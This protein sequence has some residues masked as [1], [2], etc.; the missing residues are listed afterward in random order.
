MTVTSPSNDEIGLWVKATKPVSYIVK[1]LRLRDFE[2]EQRK[3][4][5]KRVS[6]PL[7][8]DCCLLL[9]KKPQEGPYPDILMSTR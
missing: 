2:G 3:H 1:G 9:S 8:L 5:T 7:P 6:L 4:L